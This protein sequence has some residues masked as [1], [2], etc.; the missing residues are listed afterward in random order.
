M[1]LRA[2]GD[3][4][5]LLKRLFKN[6]LEIM[7]NLWPPLMGAGIR[8]TRI[9]P[10]WKEIDVEMKLRRWNAN[11]VGTHYGGSLYSITDPF[12]MVMFI[13]ILG[14]DTIVWDKSAS[15]RFRRPGRGTVFAK[16]RI[17]D[18][19]IAEIREAL[20]KEEKIDREFSVDVKSGD[21]EIIAEVKKLLQFRNKKPG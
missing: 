5:P 13:E 9:Q 17:T 3:E 10:D 11:Y 15:I 6:N 21:G 4:V 19:Q 7:F 8:I 20:K 18:E 12:Y 1:E 2:F 16:F 14:P